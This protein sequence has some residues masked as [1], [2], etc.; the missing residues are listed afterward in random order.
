MLVLLLVLLPVLPVLLLTP[1]LLLVQGGC[2]P[3]ATT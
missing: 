3:C 1:R 2:G